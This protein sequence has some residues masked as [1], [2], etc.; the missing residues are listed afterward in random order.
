[1]VSVY[2]LKKLLFD[3]RV[4]TMSENLC[5]LLLFWKVTCTNPFSGARVNTRVKC[6]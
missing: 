6:S 2:C 3:V 4:F 1:M 5:F